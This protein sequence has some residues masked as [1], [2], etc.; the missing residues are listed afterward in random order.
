MPIRFQRH[1]KRVTF[2]LDR[3]VLKALEQFAK[4]KKSASL[5]QALEQVLQKGLEIGKVKQA[6]ILA[7]G[8][9]K[10]LRP[11]TYEMPKPLMPVKGK[12]I[13]EH[14]LELLKKYGVE[15]VII[16]I[17]YLGDRI[18][19]VLGEGERFGLN[20]IYV[21]EDKPLGTAGP[22]ILAKKYLGGSFFLFWADILAALDLYAFIHFHRQ[23]KPIATLA[24]ATVENVKD[25]G[26]VELEGGLIKKFLE[27]PKPNETSSHLINSGIA[28]IEPK[29]FDYLPK[30]IKPVSIEKE[31][32]PQLAKRKKLAGY[33]FSGAWF[34]TGTIQRYEEAVKKWK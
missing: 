25:L 28:L 16:S 5:S 21:K 6:V 26:V 32:Y 29:I 3:E 18:K 22:L 24:L 13:I 30:Q 23:I 17:G 14:I 7:G 33:A 12:P 4:D 10:R 27:K 19:A 1:Y 15:E 31:V 34:D 2:S 9:G 8:K 11:F 20:I